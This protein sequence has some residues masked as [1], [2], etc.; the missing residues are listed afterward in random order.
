[1]SLSSFLSQVD[2]QLKDDEGDT[3][4]FIANGEWA[5]LG[6]KMQKSSSIVCPTMDQINM[7]VS[8]RNEKSFVKTNFESL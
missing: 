4:T 2:F 6:M 8:E 3:G 5:L 1:M 7:I